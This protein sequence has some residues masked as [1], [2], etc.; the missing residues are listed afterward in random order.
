MIGYSESAKTHYIKEVFEQS[1]VSDIGVIVIDSIDTIVEYY[2]DTYGGGLRFMSSLYN[3]IKTLIKK[4]PTKKNHKLLVI[5]NY[6]NMSE[7][8]NY[9]DIHKEMPLIDEIN[10][11]STQF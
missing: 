1:Y 9:V 6:D 11:I 10:T 2:R 3:S 4:I 5:I 8:N 7:F